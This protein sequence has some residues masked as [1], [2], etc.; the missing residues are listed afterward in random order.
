M[1]RL[2][3]LSVLSLA[4]LFTPAFSQGTNPARP[5][6]INYVEGQAAVNGSEISRS[7]IGHAEVAAGQLLST[8]N[9]KAEMLLTPGVFLRLDDN[10]VVKMISPDLMHTEIALQRGRAE[11]EV[12]Q[13]SKANDLQVDVP[14]GSG[15]AQVDLVQRGL[16]EVDARSGELKV[17]NGKAAVSESQEAKWIDVK[18]G[19]ELALNGAGFKGTSFSR[20]NSEDE[21][22]SWSSLR[23]QY[24][25][26]ANATFGTEYAGAGG[27]PGWA[28]APGSYGYTWFPED[29]LFYSP[30]GFGFYSP[31][32]FYGGYGFRGGY[33]YGGGFGYGGGLRAGF[34]GGGF[35]GGGGGRR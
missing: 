13:L 17:F 11:I 28:W 24:L 26:Q 15:G 21:L 30:F 10:S 4:T 14:N 1:F 33:G 23:S 2:K 22:Y 32:F 34:A 29:G 3:V 25:G 19:H 20:S 7:S 5:G 18:G 35:H 12:D 6:T 27:Y 9:G 31:A 8:G 16:Y